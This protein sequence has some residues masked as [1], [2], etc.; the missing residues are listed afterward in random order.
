MGTP[1]MGSPTPVHGPGRA[2]VPPP[3]A[4]MIPDNVKTFVLFILVVAVGYLIFDNYQFQQKTSAELA[5]QSS[6][7]GVLQNL[8]KASEAKLLGLKE[9]IT[10]TQQAVGSTK[11][12]LK[13]TAQQAQQQIQSESQKTKAELNQAISTKAD[14]SQVQAQVQAAKSEAEAKIGQVSTE[15][16]G[17]KTEVGVVKSDLA[18]TKRDLEGTQ[19][20][21]VDV[22]ETL[23]AAVAKNAGELSELRRKG[24]RDYFEFEIPKKNQL[25]KVE[26]IR[27][28]LRGTDPKKGKYTLQIIVDD[29]KLEK[30]DR[31]INEPIQFLVGRNRLRYEVVVNWVQKDK[32]GGYLSIPKD[33]ALGADRPA[34]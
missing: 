29:N 22:R 30:K 9:E 34:K 16:G 6:Q 2:P 31:A 13:K 21:L 12:E 25:T 24:E 3:Q 11:A 26:D 4:G 1:S 23:T 8:D 28:M 27:L 20:Q 32:L 14:S 17:V 5:K 7:I 33:K 10:G 18:T 19:R 15:V